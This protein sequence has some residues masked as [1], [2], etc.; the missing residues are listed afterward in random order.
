MSKHPCPDAV[1]S[2]TAGKRGF[3]TLQLVPVPEDRP[4]RRVGEG[5][6]LLACSPIWLAIPGANAS[7]ATPAA[8]W[9]EVGAEVDEIQVGMWKRPLTTAGQAV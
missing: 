4:T 3:P 1:Q 9:G 5:P 6:V 8:A 2:G 7:P